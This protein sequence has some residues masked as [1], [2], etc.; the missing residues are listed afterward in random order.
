MK[1]LSNYQWYFSQKQNKKFHNL[2][3]NTKDPEQPKNLE[4][5]EQN[6]RNQPSPLQTI[7]QEYSHQDRMILAQ[8]NID[9]WNKIE[10]PE[11]NPYIYGY[12]N[13]TKEAKTYYGEKK[14]S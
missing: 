2:Y 10:S 3:G 11:I 5:E 9:Q 8:G 1:F 12:H 7:P 13:F 4:K 14:V 6:W